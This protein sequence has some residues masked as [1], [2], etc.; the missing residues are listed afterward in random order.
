M[1][2]LVKIPVGIYE[3]AFPEEYSLEQILASAKQPLY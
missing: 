2:S 3:K 1:A